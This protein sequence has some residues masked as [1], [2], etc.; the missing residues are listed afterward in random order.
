MIKTLSEEIPDAKIE[1]LFFKR[2]V[3]VGL[4]ELDEGKGIPHEEVEKR[5]ARWLT[6]SEGFK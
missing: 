3:D 1:E 5:M 2:Q 6:C 4:K